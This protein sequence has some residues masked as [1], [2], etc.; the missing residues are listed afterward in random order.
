[1]DSNVKRRVDHERH[2]Q[3]LARVIEARGGDDDGYASRFLAAMLNQA[4][5]KDKAAVEKLVADVDAWRRARR[6]FRSF[7]R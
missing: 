6:T 4:N 2:V 7:F 3:F 5:L 1:M